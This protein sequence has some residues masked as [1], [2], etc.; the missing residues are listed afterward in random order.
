MPED[1]FALSRKDRRDA[2]EAAA[3]AS[4]R[5]ADLLEKDVWVVW[6]LRALFEGPFA[7]DLRFKGG[8][9][10]SKAYRAIDRF[11]EDMDLTYDIRALL[12][13]LEGE[14]P[15]PVPP[16]RSQEKRWTKAARAALA[17]WV[18]GPARK[19][20]ELGIERAGLALDVKTD[21]E[22]LRVSYEPVTTPATGY[23][24]PQ[25]LLEFGARS[26]GEPAEQ[27]LVTCD[28]ADHLPDVSF[29]TATP[30][31]MAP[32]RTFWE[33]ATAIH[34]FCFQARIRGERYS[35][36]W[37]DL[38]QL[39]QYGIV[40]RAL[41]DRGLARRVARHK[42]WFFREK[43]AAGEIISYEDAVSGLLRL[44]PEGRGKELL[45]EDYQRMA[46][47]G[48]LPERALSFDE[49]LEG[50]RDIESRANEGFLRGDR[51]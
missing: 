45:E 3:F 36:H 37:Y 40:D 25:V 35:R 50:C 14:D 20:L 8:T 9:S 32:E 33:K 30:K 4:G 13:D 22:N 29:P 11:S 2:L 15:D 18:E 12:P 10:L 46:D 7:P 31:V 47:S 51:G 44:V 23:V 41:G 49:V 27:V 38:V 1:F 39:D 16:S 48:L 21:G 42:G 19:V 34:V 28:A 26:T 6:S 24:V 5:P 43:D 17:E